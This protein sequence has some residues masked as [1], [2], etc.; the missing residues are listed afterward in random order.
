MASESFLNFIQVCYHS[1]W[2][3][4]DVIVSHDISVQ[5]RHL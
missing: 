3:E 1:E 4:L 5:G 2:F